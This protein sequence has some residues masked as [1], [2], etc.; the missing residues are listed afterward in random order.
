MFCLSEKAPELSEERKQELFVFIKNAGISFNNLQL[1][2]NAFIHSSFAN[3]S[4]CS[5]ITDNERLEFLGDSVLQLV[6]SDWL[7]SNLHLNEGEYTKIRSFVVSEDSLGEVAEV[8][9]INKYIL[10]GKGE[11][12]SGGRHKKPILADCVEAV[13]ASIYLDQGYNAAKEFILKLLVPHLD[14]VVKNKH[15]RDFKTELQEFSQKH[16]KRVPDYI[17]ERVTGPDHNQ[18]FY[19]KVIVNNRSFG[20]ACGKNKK[21]AEQNVAKLAWAELGLR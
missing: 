15:H 8:L 18:E 2:N 16:Y 19:Y 10:V 13:F 6:I 11:E 1:L 5:D 7:F 21:E 12:S 9:E 4:K 3:E 14:D 17:L 20:P